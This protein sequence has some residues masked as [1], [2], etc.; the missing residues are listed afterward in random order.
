MSLE[1][2]IRGWDGHDVAPMEALFTAHGDDGDLGPTLVGLAARG[3]EYELGAT[4]LLKRHLA[5]GGVLP[6]AAVRALYSALDGFEEWGSALH[7]LQSLRRMGVPA[8]S[9]AEVEEFV[10]DSLDGDNKFLR[11]WAYEGLFVLA[12]EFP[13]LKPEVRTRCDTA[14]ASESPA[15][16]A[17][18]RNLLGR[19]F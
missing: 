4:W 11:A 7:L 2:G 17:R 10:R 16:K 1:S 8:E 9:R 6:P 15:V 14:L 18:V 13:E 3:P 5:E 12:D 19:G